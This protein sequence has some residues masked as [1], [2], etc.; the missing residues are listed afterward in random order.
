MGNECV[1]DEKVLGVC[2]QLEIFFSNAE[3]FDV[4]PRRKISVSNHMCQCGTCFTEDRCSFIGFVVVYGA[5][6]WFYWLQ[7]ML[8]FNVLDFFHFHHYCRYLYQIW[9][10]HRYHTAILA[11]QVSRKI[12]QGSSLKFVPHH[13]L[14]TQ[15]RIITFD[16]V[17]TLGAGCCWLR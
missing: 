1:Y 11:G 4:G 15:R 3:R 8:K 12:L 7:T 10:A 6:M 9:S 13:W 2:C 16:T 17:M 14:R 5:F